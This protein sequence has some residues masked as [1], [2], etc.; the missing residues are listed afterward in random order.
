MTI[1]YA[2]RETISPYAI[3]CPHCRSRLL[4]GGAPD[5]NPNAPGMF[6]D[7][8]GEAF[9]VITLLSC[10]AAFLWWLIGDWI[11]WCL[12]TALT[13]LNWLAMALA[14]IIL[15]IINAATW[16]II[17]VDWLVQLLL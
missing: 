2:C 6:A 12:G 4:P 8:G 11:M 9:F 3:I 17:Q 13:V 16:V 5:H 7:G 1:C 10:T 14:W 15:Q